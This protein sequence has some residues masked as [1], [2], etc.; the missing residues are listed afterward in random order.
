MSAI[1][2]LG[3]P[4]N[5]S[6]VVVSGDEVANDNA[7]VRMKALA[8][9]Y[10]FLGLASGDAVFFDGVSFLLRFVHFAPRWGTIYRDKAPSRQPKL[11]DGRGH[12]GMPVSGA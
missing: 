4:D 12:R 11:L 8:S 10:A 1:F 3:V 6:L 9:C 7:E 2:I 5:S